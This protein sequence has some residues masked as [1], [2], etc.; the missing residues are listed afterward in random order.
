MKAGAA[1]ELEAPAPRSLPGRLLAR[2]P[3]DA[4]VFVVAMIAGVAVTAAAGAVCGAAYFHVLAPFND[5]LRSKAAPSYTG[6]RE[7]V[8]LAHTCRSGHKSS[9]CVCPQRDRRTLLEYQGADLRQ[10]RY[11]VPGT[12]PLGQPVPVRVGYSSNRPYPLTWTTVGHT[13]IRGALVGGAL[14]LAHA[15][16]LS[17]RLY[18]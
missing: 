2:L 1:P 10:R 9:S 11:A 12:Y 13:A 15:V 6:R 18:A 4:E 17:L 8:V 5:A 14:G 16:L 7:A 3:Y